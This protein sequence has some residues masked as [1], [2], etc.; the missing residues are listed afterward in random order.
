LNFLFLE[1]N[2]IENILRRN[3]QNRQLAY[4]LGSEIIEPWWLAWK[5]RSNTAAMGA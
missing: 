4:W 5:E 2:F 3:K 1:N